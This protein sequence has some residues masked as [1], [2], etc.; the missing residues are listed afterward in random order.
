[1]QEKHVLALYQDN[2]FLESE[3]YSVVGPHFWQRS[4]YKLSISI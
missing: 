2:I 4:S 3:I 1:M